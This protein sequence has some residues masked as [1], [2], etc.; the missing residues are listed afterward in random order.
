MGDLILCNYPIAAMPF[1]REAFS[2][3]VYSLEELCYYIE[4]N[5]FLLEEE[6]FEEELFDW[7]ESEVGAKE[8]AKELRLS[9]QEG[10]RIADF[11]MLLWKETGYWDAKTAGELISQINGLG[12]KST[13]ERKKLRADRYVE[14]KR[15]FPA[16]LEYRR[17]LQLEEACKKD[18]EMCGNIW[19]NQ[20]VCFVRLF[21]FEEAKDCF[22]TAYKYH[23]KIESIQNALIACMYLANE[24]EAERIRVHYGVSDSDYKELKEQWQASLESNEVISFQEQLDELFKDG[25]LLSENPKLSQMLLKWQNEYQKNCR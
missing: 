13:L 22:L 14:H 19:H 16:I 12:Q 24:E 20:G 8:L 25:N 6:L 3:N 4:H 7:I 11:V 2:G 21:L 15:Y 23:R 18:T 17:I 9:K 10:K 5:L 1:Y